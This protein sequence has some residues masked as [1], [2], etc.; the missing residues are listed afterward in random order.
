M[1]VG[2]RR[3]PWLVGERVRDLEKKDIKTEILRPFLSAL[4]IFVYEGT[5]GM[6]PPDL[7][8]C[9]DALMRDMFA[10]EGV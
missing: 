7:D 3:R 1:V 4:S 2:N 10:E 8:S 9:E 5:Y 6:K